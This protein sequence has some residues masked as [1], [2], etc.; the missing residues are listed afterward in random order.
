MNSLHDL[1]IKRDFDV[2]PEVAAIKSYVH[3]EFGA[4]VAVQLRDKDIVISGRSSG[5]IGRLRLHLTQVQKAAA[6]DK[7]LILRVG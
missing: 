5:L 6:T 3:Q 7:K 2:P 1:L 4:E